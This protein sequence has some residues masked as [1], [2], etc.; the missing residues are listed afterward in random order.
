[1]CASLKSVNP[2]G[3]SKWAGWAQAS[4]GRLGPGV[5]G[6]AGPRR[7]WVGW[8]QASVGWLAP[9]I[10]GPCQAGPSNT[11]NKHVGPG[12]TENSTEWAGP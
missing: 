5:S 8:P 3:G 4:M 12:E 10:N 2:S 11:A 7:Q 6:P 9:G 1:M